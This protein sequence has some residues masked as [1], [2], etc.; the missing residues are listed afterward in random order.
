LTTARGWLEERGAGAPAAL[1]NRA[2]HYLEML[3]PTTDPADDLARAGLAALEATTGS[4]G[5]RRAA[6][7]L[8]AA[9]GLVTLALMVRAETDPAALADFAVR[10]R[11]A[12]IT[13]L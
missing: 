12:G 2:H 11:N 4:A 6:L 13:S 7:D 10:I 3:E 9:D 8:L 5:D 1:L